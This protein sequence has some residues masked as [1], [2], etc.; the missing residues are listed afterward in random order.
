M[1][2]GKFTF[3]LSR[4]VFGSQQAIKPRLFMTRV[5]KRLVSTSLWLSQGGKL[6]MVNF[7]LSS[8][9]TFYMCSIKVPI[10]IL[11]QID[12]YRCHCLWLGGDVNVK[13]P[14]KA[15]SKLITR[16]KSKGGLGIIRLR[17]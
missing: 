7:V 4:L 1:L 3:Y 5:E 6:Q 15:V 9:P 10:N 8:L 11:N 12:M 17:L 16:L 14:P 13:K 2:S